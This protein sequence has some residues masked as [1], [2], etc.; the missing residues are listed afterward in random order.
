MIRHESATRCEGPVRAQAVLDAH[1]RA[2]ACSARST[3]AAASERP[4]HEWVRAL[5]GKIQVLAEPV[6]GSVDLDPVTALSVKALRLVRVVGLERLGRREVTTLAAGELPE[7]DPGAPQF[8]GIDNVTAAFLHNALVGGTPGYRELVPDPA[9][10]GGWLAR[11][12]LRLSVPLFD[13]ANRVIHE[14]PRIRDT[15]MYASLMAAISAGESAPAKIGGLLGR[16]SSSL[17]YQ[18]GARGGRRRAQDDRLRRLVCCLDAAAAVGWRGRHD[19][20]AVI[21]WRAACVHPPVGG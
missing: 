6:E 17:T 14:D 20:A 3:A 5:A 19:V 4:A 1:H 8:W 13:E 16:P 15:A 10:M 12:V 18:L 21:E 11:N 2:P 9:L 7:S